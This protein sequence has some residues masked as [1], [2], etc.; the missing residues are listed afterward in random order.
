LTA[1]LAALQVLRL[2]RADAHQFSCHSRAPKSDALIGAKQ[3]VEPSP[4]PL[5]WVGRQSM[6]VAER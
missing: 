2:L 3:G 4:R 5:G 1:P 6:G